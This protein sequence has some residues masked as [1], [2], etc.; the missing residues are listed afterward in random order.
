MVKQHYNMNLQKD[1][2]MIYYK[3]DLVILIL[4][5]HINLKIMPLQYF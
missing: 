2:F 4:E 5:K 1:M 3:I